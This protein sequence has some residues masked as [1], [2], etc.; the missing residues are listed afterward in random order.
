MRLL[1]PVL[2]RVLQI[3]RLVLTVRIGL[4]IRESHRACG[5]LDVRCGRHASAEKLCHAFAM[6]WARFLLVGAIVIGVIPRYAIATRVE[7][8][9]VDGQAVTPNGRRNVRLKITCTSLSLDVP[10]IQETG[11]DVVPFQGM[12]AP[13]RT[14]ALSHL[15]V[16]TVT[17]VAERTLPAN[18]S[19]SVEPRGSVRVRGIPPRVGDDLEP[20][21]RHRVREHRRGGALDAEGRWRCPQSDRRKLY[22]SWF[23]ARMA[24]LDGES[25]LPESGDE[26]GNNEIAD[27]A[28]AFD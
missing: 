15:Q 28:D 6:R 1:V 17:G 2:A 23:T 3:E 25:V 22:D 13:A 16:I 5:I 27:N 24:V 14:K 10:D 19:Y 9:I 26:L 7:T 20:R 12:D 11:F 18:L 8:V 21:S 4:W